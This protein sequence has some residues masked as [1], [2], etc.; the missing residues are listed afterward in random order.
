MSPM[1][2]DPTDAVTPS[3]SDADVPSAHALPAPSGRPYNRGH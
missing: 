1:I 2:P 3:G